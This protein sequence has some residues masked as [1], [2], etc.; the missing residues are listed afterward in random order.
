MFYRTI[1]INGSRM[2]VP[3]F[4]CDSYA[5][6]LKSARMKL[7]TSRWEKFLIFIGLTGAR[8]TSHPRQPHLP[9]RSER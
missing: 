4:P 6:V 3:C 1:E 7:A 2:N 5:T 9:Q 8:N